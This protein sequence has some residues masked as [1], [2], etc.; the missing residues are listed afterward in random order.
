MSKKNL[1][2]IRGV[3][4]D[5]VAERA[6]DA[7]PRDPKPGDDKGWGYKAG[8]WPGAPA[9]SLPPKM[10]VIPLGRDGE[11]YYFMD[12]MKQLNGVHR[13]KWGKKMLLDLFAARP[14]Y[15][16]HH[17]PRWSEPK[18][19]KGKPKQSVINGLEVDDAIQCLMHA[20]ANEGAIEIGA[21][22][23]GRGAWAT[24]TGKLV[25]HAGDQL[26][27]VESGGLVAAEPSAIEGVIYPGAAPIMIPWREPVSPED[28][29]AAGI[30]KTLRTW[31]WERPTLDPILI[32]GWIAAAFLGA[33]L[34][35][36]PYLFFA[37]GA[38]V[39]KSTLQNMLRALMA[40]ALIKA[41]NATEASL[42]Q[43]GN[44]DSL[45]IFL[46]E[47]EAKADNRKNI[48]ILE[49]ARIAASG[50][51]ILRG[52]ADHRGAKFQMRSCFLFSAINPPDRKSTRLNSS[53]VKRSR[54]PS[55][56]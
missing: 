14:Y 33:A 24:K 31:N 35:W 4:V 29:P 10:P 19:E 11:T 46:D 42:R 12:S 27:M 32:I 40:D 39:G 37:G 28:S 38:G 30:L 6:R 48:S 52:G 25:W 20:C 45:P 50:D 21:R 43:F 49:L 7:L 18:G 36:R 3:F 2:A 55:S 44:Q 41:A 22:V 16:E 26:Y 13:D 51:D 47:F 5:A 8:Q 17:W 56:A 53:Y 9:D 54:M 15:L 23:R 1:K 34:D